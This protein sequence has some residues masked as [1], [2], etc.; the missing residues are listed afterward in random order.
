[1]LAFLL[2]NIMSVCYAQQ[3][4]TKFMGIPIDGT[5]QDMER[6]LVEKGF[7][8]GRYDP[9][10]NREDY[11]FGIF[12]ERSVNIYIVTHKQKVYRIMVQFN[13]K[14]SDCVTIKSLFNKL[15]W[16]FENNPKYK[17]DEQDQSLSKEYNIEYEMNVN[18]QRPEAY[19]YQL[20]NT[21]KKIDYNKSVWFMIYQEEFDNQQYYGI[22]LFYDNMYNYPNNSDDL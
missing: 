17:T 14:Y 10:G 16:Q 15:C 9:Y 2:A 22:V 1:M 18:K 8:V 12:N 6:K 21:T 7:K 13:I 19:F 5:Y 11:L 4:I 20:S 3:D